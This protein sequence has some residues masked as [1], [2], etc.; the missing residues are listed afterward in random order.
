MYVKTSDLILVG[1]IMKNKVTTP[2]SNLVKKKSD[3]FL[4]FKFDPGNIQAINLLLH[5]DELLVYIYK[6][7][8]MFLFDNY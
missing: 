1:Q 4:I 8:I 3:L 5:I 6:I 2:K 7:S